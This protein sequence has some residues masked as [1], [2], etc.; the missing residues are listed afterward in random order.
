MLSVCL[1][2]ICIEVVLV[3]FLVFLGA[4]VDDPLAVF[5]AKPHTQ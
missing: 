1:V 3:V 4:L 2:R 5:H